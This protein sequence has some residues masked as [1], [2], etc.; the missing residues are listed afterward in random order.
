MELY[1]RAYA[2]VHVALEKG[3]IPVWEQV[4]STKKLE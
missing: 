4:G 1:A 2:T 3:D